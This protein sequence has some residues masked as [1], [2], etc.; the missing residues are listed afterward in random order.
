[1]AVTG[2]IVGSA[3]RITSAERRSFAG[4]KSLRGH[5]HHKS[6]PTVMWAS[7]RADWRGLPGSVAAAAGQSIM[8]YVHTKD[9]PA[10]REAG[11]RRRWARSDA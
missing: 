11:P 9:A 2:A 3:M 6:Q 4:L 7:G 8:A 1:M 10:T 5:A